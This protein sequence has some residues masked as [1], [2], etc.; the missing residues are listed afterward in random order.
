MPG[1]TLFLTCTTLPAISGQHKLEYTR[2]FMIFTHPHTGTEQTVI[3]LKN[4]SNQNFIIIIFKTSL[5][6]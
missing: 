3:F 6:L 4:S 2:T 1:V 5:N